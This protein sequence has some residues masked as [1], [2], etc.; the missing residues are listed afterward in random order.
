MALFLRADEP[1]LHGGIRIGAAGCAVLGRGHRHGAA[2][3][4]GADHDFV[5]AAISGRVARDMDAEFALVA[6]VALRSG[7]A[8]RSGITLGTRD[9]LRA[10]L[11]LGS[12]RSRRSG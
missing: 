4:H 10:A 6:A 3:A 1:R 11:A 2:E 9:A 5:A 12:G 7:R 8:L